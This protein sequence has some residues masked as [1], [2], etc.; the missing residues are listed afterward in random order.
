MDVQKWNDQVMD[1]FI[2]ET[3]CFS[4]ELM[5]MPDRSAELKQIRD[6]VAD[7]GELMERRDL[8]LGAEGTYDEVRFI[9]QQVI[10]RRDAVKRILSRIRVEDDK[11]EMAKLMKG[12]ERS[13]RWTEKEDKLVDQIF[14]MTPSI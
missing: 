9:E 14:A 3:G 10:E 7:C 5:A 2:H 11:A 4:A 8:L 1:N 6:F 12:K 13:G